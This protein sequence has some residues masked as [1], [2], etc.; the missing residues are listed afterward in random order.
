MADISRHSLN[1]RQRKLARLL[2]NGTTQNEAYLKAYGREGSARASKLAAHPDVIAEVERLQQSSEDASIMEREEMIRYLLTILQ[3]PVSEL[4]PDHP[5]TQELIEFDTKAAS[6]RRVKGVCKLGAAKLLCAM[7][8]WLRVEKPD[9]LSE[10]EVTI[11]LKK[12]WEDDPIIPNTRV[13]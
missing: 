5:A 1:P 2:A 3:T 12:V 6:R 7:L 4:H 13:A 9:R 11:I 10:R 8:G